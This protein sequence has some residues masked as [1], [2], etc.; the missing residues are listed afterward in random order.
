MKKLLI[1]FVLLAILVGVSPIIGNKIVEHYVE[2]E[3]VEVRKNG[4]TLDFKSEEPGY[5]YT[6]RQY[7]FV[8]SDVDAF[9][10]YLTEYGAG[11]LPPYTGEL[12]KSIV[13]RL[14]MKYNNIPFLEPISIDIYPMYL[15]DGILSR[16]EG[17]GNVFFDEFRR[18]ITRQGI[19]YHIDYDLLSENYKG[20]ITNIDYKERNY[21]G[22]NVILTLHNAIFNGTGSFSAPKSLQT[23]V[24]KI[25][26]QTGDRSKEVSLEINKFSSKSSV[27]V[28]DKAE[29]MYDKSKEVYEKTKDMYNKSDIP[30][31]INKIKDQT[32]DTARDMYNTSIKM[33]SM[34]FNTKDK[35]E[36]TSV[37]AENVD[38]D[39]S[40]EEGEKKSKNRSY[41][42]FESLNLK[43][44][45]DAVSMSHVVYESS[46][47][48]I[49]TVSLKKMQS[50]LAKLKTSPSADII[51]DLKVSG[52]NLLSHGVKLQVPELS[53]QNI[54]FKGEDLGGFK[55]VSA[56]YVKE[57]EDLAAKMLFSPFFIVQNLDFKVHLKVSK[58]IYAKFIE[59]VP[60][61]LVALAATKQTANELVYDISYMGGDLKING[62]SVL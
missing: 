48:E 11:M 29:E 35:N 45:K 34:F 52:I 6:S 50:L 3:I 15:S 23:D 42:F 12:L 21:N 49:D 5:L 24:E 37:E 41:F 27:K 10:R 54:H 17:K 8:L 16:F 25:L 40:S 57:D 58:K 53:V 60:F 56:F 2:Q 1:F 62:T 14:D 9:A 32:E 33:Q 19:L 22:S 20:H 47:S 30:E 61:A 7:E 18:F 28:S 44:N 55:L 39:I 38:V 4:I 46:L 13:F 26:I 31:H 51:N 59:E 43:S 36:D